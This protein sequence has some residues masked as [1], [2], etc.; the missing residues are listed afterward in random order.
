MPIPLLFAVAT[1]SVAAAPAAPS[2]GQDVRA[3]AESAKGCVRPRTRHASI[4]RK[5]VRPERLI[6]LPPGRLELTVVREID[7]CPLPAVLREG[8]GAR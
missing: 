5:P 6:D 8:I 3:P 2:A 7:G 1:L 4:L